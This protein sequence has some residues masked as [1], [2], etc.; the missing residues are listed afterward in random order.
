[1]PCS[2]AKLAWRCRRGMLELDVWL[3][4]FLQRTDLNEA[5]C[6]NML[7]LLDAE[8]DEIYDWLLGRATPP[9]RFAA[10]IEDMKR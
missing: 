4:R 5:E 3:T 7:A 8:D 10:L 2:K 9:A 6:A 1:M